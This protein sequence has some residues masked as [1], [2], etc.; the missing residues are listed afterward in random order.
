MAVGLAVS[1][2]T[3]HESVDVHLSI[4]LTAEEF[5]YQN[6]WGEIALLTV[7]N[8]SERI[9]MANTTYV[10]HLQYRFQSTSFVP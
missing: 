3:I 2:S 6:Q 9:L 1:A 10:S 5:L 7:G 8:L 4:P